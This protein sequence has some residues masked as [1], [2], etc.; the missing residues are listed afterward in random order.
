MQPSLLRT[1]VV[2]DQILEN[3]RYATQIICL[4]VS[5]LPRA[6]DPSLIKVREDVARVQRARQHKLQS[7][8]WQ[9]PNTELVEIT[10]YSLHTIISY[11]RRHAPETLTRYRAAAKIDWDAVDMALP[12]PEICDVTGCSERVARQKKKERRTF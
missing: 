10:G 11:R 3:I 6:I 5:V 9:K 8:D 12:V 4:P 7:L 1:T 2:L